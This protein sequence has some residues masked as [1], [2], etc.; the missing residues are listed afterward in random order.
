MEAHSEPGQSRAG[1]CRE[2]ILGC[3][4]LLV[5]LAGAWGAVS[6]LGYGLPDAAPLARLLP[7]FS[8]VWLI[9]STVAAILAAVAPFPLMLA[10]V[11]AFDSHQGE[12]PR[13]TNVIVFFWV[14][15][16]VAVATIAGAWACYLLDIPRL[17]GYLSLGPWLAGLGLLATT[18]ILLGTAAQGWNRPR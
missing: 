15:P 13:R 17:S 5:V 9:A 6:G 3:G 14:L 2:T 4:C 16:V 1:G 10:S 12:L 7:P 8:L 18:G 11:M